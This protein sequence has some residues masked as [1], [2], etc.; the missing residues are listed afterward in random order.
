M[1]IHWLL[2]SLMFTGFEILFPPLYTCPMAFPVQAH[3]QTAPTFPLNRTLSL[4]PLGPG[5]LSLLSTNLAPCKEQVFNSIFPLASHVKTVCFLQVKQIVKK[6]PLWKVS[7]ST[8]PPHL[9][10]ISDVVWK[11]HPWANDSCV[12]CWGVIY[13]PLVCGGFLS[14]RTQ[15]PQG[16]LH[17]WCQTVYFT[18]IRWGSLWDAAF[19]NSYEQSSC[20]RRRKKKGKIKRKNNL[21]LFC[22]FLNEITS[23]LN[24]ALTISSLKH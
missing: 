13:S 1:Y 15:A 7:R 19:V 23:I 11:R 6:K 21:G 14:W 18:N 3:F 12:L 4:M 2:Y 22:V 9:K 24:P 17:D 16:F 8:F 5:L 10:Q 20:W